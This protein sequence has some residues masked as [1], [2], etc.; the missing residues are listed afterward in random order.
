MSFNDLNIIKCHLITMCLYNISIL[1][2]MKR[3]SDLTV[4]FNC[5]LRSLILSKY[6]I[7]F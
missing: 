2:S 4:K 7:E 3:A 6:F 5:D 1:E